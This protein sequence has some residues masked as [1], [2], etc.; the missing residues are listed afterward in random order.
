MVGLHGR[1]PPHVPPNR[2]RRHHLRHRR[3]HEPPDPLHAS[4]HAS[5]RPCGVRQPRPRAYGMKRG[6][7][8]AQSTTEG[9]GAAAEHVGP[10][11]SQIL[12]NKKS[13]VTCFCFCLCDG[14]AAEH[15]DFCQQGM[16]SLA[17]T[18]LR[19]V[20]AKCALQQQDDDDADDDDHHRAADDDLI[21]CSF[22]YMHACIHTYIHKCMHAYARAHIHTYIHAY[23]HA[24]IHTHIHTYIS[25][26]ASRRAWTSMAWTPMDPYGID[27]Y[28]P[29]WFRP[30]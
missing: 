30:L 25:V 18:H 27:P 13:S 4:D 17:Q 22:T 11:I 12:L 8:A 29:L 3:Q 6:A 20:N 16:P 1:A 21:L 2:C 9:N 10:C 28:G 19:Q 5:A 15:A 7:P 24:Y 26:V 14:A 23:I